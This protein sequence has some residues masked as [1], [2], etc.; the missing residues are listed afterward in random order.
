MALIHLVFR[1][2]LSD[3]FL[4]R[5]QHRSQIHLPNRFLLLNQDKNPRKKS[6]FE[7]NIKSSAL[8][9]E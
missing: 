9:Q 4:L 6:K 8:K 1:R 7:K 5:C 3:V 2:I